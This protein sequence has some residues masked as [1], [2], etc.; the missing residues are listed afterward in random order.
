MRAW[1]PGLAVISLLAHAQSPSAPYPL[2]SLT[3]EGNK[4]FTAAQIIAAAGLKAGQLVSKET[5][6]AARGRLMET[7]AFESVGYGFKPNE[8]KTGY[9]AA[10]EVAE[11]ALMYRYRF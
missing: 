1:L 6:D 8:A 7:G 11:V 3:V 10:F 5:F 2:T 4:R 9:D